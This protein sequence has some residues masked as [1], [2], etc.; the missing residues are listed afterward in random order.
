MAEKLVPET[1]SKIKTEHMSGATVSSFIQFESISNIVPSYREFGNNSNSAL[2]VSILKGLLS[3]WLF[4][5]F[6]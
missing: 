4:Y 2:F 3:F 5:L 6:S 1:F